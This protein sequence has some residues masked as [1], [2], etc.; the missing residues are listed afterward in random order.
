MRNRPLK[1][2]LV[3]NAPTRRGG[4]IVRWLWVLSTMTGCVAILGVPDLSFDERAEQGAVDGSSRPGDAARSSD[5][6]SLSSPA[7]SGPASCK[8]DL[9]TDTRNCG[10]C[11]HD[12]THGFCND[13]LCTLKDDLGGPTALALTADHVYVG[14]IGDNAL[15]G[16][17]RCPKDGC[18]SPTVGPERISPE[19]A[20]Y[21]EVFG[22]VTSPNYVFAT[23]YYGSNGGKAWRMNLDGGGLSHV[24]EGALQQRSYGIAIDRTHLYWV[25]AY[26]PGGLYD[27][28]LPEC[29]SPHLIKAL[30]GPELI[31]VGPDQR[32]AYTH[33]DG[34]QLST[35]RSKDDCG[36][37][38]L[39]TSNASPGYIN[40]IA[41]DD[42]SVFFAAGGQIYSCA[43]SP[44]CAN[45][46]KVV[47]EVGQLVTTFAVS[48]GTLW[49]AVLPID[50]ADN[51]VSAEGTIKT[52]IATQCSGAGVRVIATKQ[53]DP[54]AIALDD[55]SVYWA[56]NG[57]RR[58]TA[59]IG[60]VV[61]APR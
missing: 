35:C 44:L 6:G 18:A 27:C 20:G 25:D 23:D 9:K 11:G 16:V 56:N 12:C 50:D 48:R 13:G 5:D 24:P 59:G 43:L 42:G 37:P 22:L 14:L 52:C 8:A 29:K 32:I 3:A 33:Q 45:P 57:I 40:A 36:A 58:S 39:V 51:A 26:D 10:A 41:I 55:K 49:F 28:A 54:E 19:D 7:D 31:A 34:Y 15:Q 2:G 38:Q 61:K 21:M 4:A 53:K 30:A 1:V 46:T 47:D 60:S 17:I